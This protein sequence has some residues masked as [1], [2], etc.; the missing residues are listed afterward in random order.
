MKKGEG[1]LVS[2]SNEMTVEHSFWHGT[3][4]AWIA[5]V[6][7]KVDFELSNWLKYEFPLRFTTKRIRTIKVRAFLKVEESCSHEKLIFLLPSVVMPLSQGLQ[8]RTSI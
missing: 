7:E 3:M 8:N 2:C 1:V 6:I 4:R 5:E